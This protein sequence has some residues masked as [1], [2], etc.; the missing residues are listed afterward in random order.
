MKRDREIKN[1]LLQEENGL[2]A[3]HLPKGDESKLTVLKLYLL[4]HFGQ[5]IISRSAN[6]A[7]VGQ[8]SAGR[9][10]TIIKIP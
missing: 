6:N 8:F 7:E 1:R 4:R 9:G 10:Y 3:N 5:G 2:K